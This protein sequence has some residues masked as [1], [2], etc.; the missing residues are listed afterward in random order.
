ML[1][2]SAASLGPASLDARPPEWAGWLGLLV[3]VGAFALLA[4]WLFASPLPQP[5][6]RVATTERVLRLRLRM[7]AV[8]LLSGLLLRVGAPWDELWHRRYGVPFGEDLL[9]PP[10]LLMYASFALSFLLVAV[11]LAVA[12]RG[13]GGLRERVR[14]EPLLALLGLLAAYGFAFIPVDVVWHQVIGPDLTAES[15]PHVVGALSGVA[16]ALTGV[17]LALSTAPRPV[18]RGLLDRPRT[19]DAVTLGILVVQ[20]LNWLQLLTTGWEWA[21]PVVLDRPGW[22]YPV[23][24]LVVGA[25]VSHLA[26]HATRRV[27]AA[28][29]VALAVLAAHAPVVA[30]Y[31]LLLPPGPAIAAHLLV[32]PAAVALDVWYA[33][34]TGAGA[35]AT[36]RWGGAL[37][38]AA[39]F[40]AVALPYIAGTMS[41]PVLDPPTALASVVAGLPAALVASLLGARLGAWLAEVGRPGASAIA[42]VARPAGDRVDTAP[43]PPRG[44]EPE[45]AASAVPT[46]A[47]HTLGRQ[48]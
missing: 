10:H 5:A 16:V 17:A 12:L 13:P 34:R 4:W 44:A 27:G 22:T 9:W 48:E 23:T 28:T 3:L 19:V 26:L 41:A 20:S 21:D 31:R 40:L 24:V 7:A 25:A 47:A 35:A 33:R 32:V 15:P 11:G 43:G 2:L 42:A 6:A 1:L 18:W 36:T 46:A 29:A 37:L 38:Y 14:R 39:V 30:V 45:V 8:V